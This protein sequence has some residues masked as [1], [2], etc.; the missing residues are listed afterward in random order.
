M[1]RRHGLQ[2][3]ALLLALGLALGTGTLLGCASGGGDAAYDESAAGEAGPPKGVPA[4]AGHPLARVQEGMQPPQ[5]EEILG[6]P[7][8]RQTY[9]TGMA[10]IPYY[11]GSDTHRTDWKYKGKG[12]VVF[13]HNRWSGVTKVIRV[14]YDPQEDGY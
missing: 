8:T 5:V 2:V 9:Q 4:P 3:P 12:R 7:T 1:A 11:W 13:G 10:W 14:D 6:Q